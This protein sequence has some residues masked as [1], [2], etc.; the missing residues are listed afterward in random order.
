M[1]GKEKNIVSLD[2]FLLTR[3]MEFLWTSLIFTVRISNFF[4]SA[5]HT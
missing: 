1:E 2:Y 4:F 3:G 5:L